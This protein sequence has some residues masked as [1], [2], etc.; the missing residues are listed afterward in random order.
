MSRIVAILVLSITIAPACGRY[1]DPVRSRP[2]A[3]S[4]PISSRGSIDPASAVRAPNTTT[5]PECKEE[6][7]P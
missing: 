5:D 4:P 6:D 7:A 1:G 2:L 3:T